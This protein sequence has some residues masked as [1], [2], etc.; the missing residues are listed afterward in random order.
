[1]SNTIYFVFLNLFFFINIFTKGYAAPYDVIY[2]ITAHEK[3]EVIHDLIR[4]IKKYNQ[5]NSFLICL[6]LNH[7]MFSNFY[8]D[9]PCVVVNP[10]PYDKKKFTH[11]ILKAHLDNYDYLEKG[12]IEFRSIM[13]LA[14]NCMFIKQMPPIPEFENYEQTFPQGCNI[15]HLNGW[16]WPVFKKNHFLVNCFIDH[17]IR[18][19][20]CWHEG[21]L[22]S[23]EVFGKIK[24]FIESNRLFSNISCEICFEEILLPSLEVYFQ[25][26]MAPQ[27]ITVTLERHGFTIQDIKK[28]R[29]SGSTNSFIVKRVF[30]NMNDPVRQ[31]INS[32]P[33]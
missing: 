18:C 27:L 32:L 16:H 30:R 13:L 23:K 5:C 29:A 6:H 3:P 15:Q 24:T 11:L 2:S 14:S 9:D 26:F 19:Y 31:F 33:E 8:T 22:H 10:E 1:M 25:N 7:K 21:S 20:N 17:D 28:M 4:N 12:G